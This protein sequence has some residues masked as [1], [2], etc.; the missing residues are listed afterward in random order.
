LSNLQDAMERVMARAANVP[1]PESDD[2]F[3]T[4]KPTELEAKQS[5]LA[6]IFNGPSIFSNACF[7]HPEL[8]ETNV[9]RYLQQVFRPSSKRSILV[10][11]GVGAGKT[12]GLV[13]YLVEWLYRNNSRSGGYVTAYDLA[14]MMHAKK[15]DQLEKVSRVQL[16]LIDDL[17]TEPSGW[18]GADFVAH[19]ENLFN[20]RH[21][22]LKHTFMT[23]NLTMDV[24]KEAY[25]ER[26]V[27][28]LRQ[29]GD[30]YQTSEKDMRGTA[31]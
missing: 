28:R 4:T 3:R 11:G 2:I 31:S 1:L 15:F 7:G 24:F 27:S 13:A 8:K 19:F 22:Q 12:H 16:L 21:R 6:G 30:V 20:E 5:L 14:H 23:S 17:G 26:L 9:T 29:I 10:L 25:G 18:K